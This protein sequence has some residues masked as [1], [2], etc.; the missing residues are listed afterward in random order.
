MLPPLA[1]STCALGAASHSLWV[2]PCPS[3]PKE[4]GCPKLC[5]PVLHH[6]QVQSWSEA[7]RR[8]KAK[9]KS[10]GVHTRVPQVGPSSVGWV[11]TAAQHQQLHSPPTAAWECRGDPLAE[12]G[13]A[14]AALRLGMQG[15]MLSDNCH[16]DDRL[17]ATFGGRGNCPACGCWQRAPSPG[18]AAAASLRG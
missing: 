15:R 7:C 11:T 8:C 17:K 16:G 13:E 12:A 14:G 5:R 1:L 3:S 4:A 2:Q 6:F 9:Q 10:A 18:V